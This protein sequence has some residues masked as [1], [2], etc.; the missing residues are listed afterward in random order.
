[1][2]PNDAMGKDNRIECHPAFVV[3][4]EFFKCYK[5]LYM[6]MSVHRRANVDYGLN[7]INCYY[8]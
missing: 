7:G 8:M 2:A 4:G 5:V 1:M 3:R 6:D